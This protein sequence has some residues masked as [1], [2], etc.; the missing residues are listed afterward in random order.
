MSPNF[1]LTRLAHHCQYVL[2][3]L[4]YAPLR[5]GFFSISG[6]ALEALGNRIANLARANYEPL[7]L[8]Q[9]E[10]SVVDSDGQQR[11][12]LQ[13]PSCREYAQLIIAVGESFQTVTSAALITALV[14]HLFEPPKLVLMGVSTTLPAVPFIIEAG[15]ENLADET[16]E[17]ALSCKI[18][19]ATTMKIANL[20]VSVFAIISTSVSAD[21]LSSST[22][23]S[24]L[25]PY[26]VS[27]VGNACALARDFRLITRPHD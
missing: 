3:D 14:H 12:S 13:R 21:S 2:I 5:Q 16:R 18:K 9:V 8:T 22:S 25:L 27:L 1:S 20:A 17:R 19:L 4:K 15:E 10:I 23:L 6:I 7:P 26:G 24:I 11:P